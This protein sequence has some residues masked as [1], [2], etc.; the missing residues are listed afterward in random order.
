[1]ANVLL[2]DS[3]QGWDHTHPRAKWPIANDPASLEASASF[4]RNSG[5]MR[6]VSGGSTLFTIAGQNSGT[7]FAASG[8]LEYA[9]LPFTPRSVGFAFKVGDEEPVADI[10]I[11]AFIDSGTLK[12]NS[13]TFYATQSA[14]YYC[15]DQRL[16]LY[17]GE[18]N[19]RILI[20][21]FGKV[22]RRNIFHYVELSLTVGSPGSVQAWFD[23]EE[24]LNGSYTTQALAGSA[25][26]GVRLFFHRT[27]I[28]FG[29]NERVYYIDDVYVSSGSRLSDVE[30]EYLRPNADGAHT[31]WTPSSGSDHYTMVDDLTQDDD[32]TR[33]AAGAVGNTDSYEITTLTN[34]TG[35]IHG[36]M[37]GINHKNAIPDI[38][39]LS[40]VTRQSGTDSFGAATAMGTIEYRYLTEGNTT[41]PITAS[42][43]TVEEI[44]SSIQ[45]GMKRNS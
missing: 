26:T 27:S 23:G 44:N 39:T 8:M 3:F 22:C 2:L 1:M 18:W 35:T 41:N 14:I 37:V 40:T 21:D 34:G 30:I 25:T 29:A 19:S 5:G 12:I 7:P 9:N 15:M 16:R 45:F 28:A 36:L 42:P 17:I 33:V 31:D 38:A 10:P 6:V 11:F 32:S 20:A 24:V 43:F 13:G 4:G